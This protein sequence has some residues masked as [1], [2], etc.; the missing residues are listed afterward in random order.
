MKKF[1]LNITFKV[2]KNTSYAGVEILKY[3]PKEVKN[4]EVNDIFKTK[5]KEILLEKSHYTFD[6]LYCM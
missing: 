1:Y 4:I 3:L 6:K 5:L 2:Q